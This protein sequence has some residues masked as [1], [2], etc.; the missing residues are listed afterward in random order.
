MG[1]VLSSARRCNLEDQH[2]QSFAAPV[3]HP[4]PK[5]TAPTICESRCRDHHAS[6]SPSNPSRL[7]KSTKQPVALPALTSPPGHP[8]HRR[9][10]GSTTRS[11]KAPQH[12]TTAAAS[13]TYLHRVDDPRRSQGLCARWCASVN[14][15][16]EHDGT[17][18]RTTKKG[19]GGGERRQSLERR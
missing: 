7:C 16:V 2:I 9:H 17:H 13:S 12:S 14:R 10:V 8:S 11:S 1:Y 5:P 15:R 6:S 19:G 4:T 18:L 3:Q